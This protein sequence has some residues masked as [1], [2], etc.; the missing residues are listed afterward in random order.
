[1]KKR[2]LMLLTVALAGSGL[3]NAQADCAREAALAYDQAKAKNYDAALP[4]LQKIRETCPKYSMATYQYLERAL[5]AKIDKAPEGQ[6]EQYVEDLIEVWEQRLELYPEKTQKGK[7]YADIAQLKYDNKLGD[8]EELYEAYDKAWNEDKESFTSP[9]G[10]YA[11]FDLVVNMQD[12]GERSLQDVFDQYD[13]VF[14]KIEQEEND[15]AEALAPLL[16]KQEEGEELTAK[17]KKQIKY[18]EINLN[19]YSKVKAALNAKLGARADCDNL[20]PLYKK[21]FE[22]KKTDVSWLRNANAR[23]SAKDCTEDPLFVQVSEALHKLEPSAKS[24]FSLGQL[25][26]ANG[27]GAKALQYYNEAAELETNKSDKARIYYRI[28]GNYKDKGSYG[29]ARSFYRKA[30]DAKPSLGSAYL[31]IA[32]MYAKSANSCGTDTFTKRA[33]Y[34]LAADYASRAARV[35]PSIASNANQAASSYRGL[36]PQKSDIFQSSYNA[37]QTIS[38]GCWIGESVRVPNL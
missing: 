28:A 12:A 31:Q 6:K 25:A 13:K 34:W 38:I 16:K 5:E 23:L 30:L 15:A 17:E 22:A 27:D 29:Q 11:Y 2:I 24:A 14:G 32:S 3:A 4:A 21:D 33:V 20:I 8:E 7:I 9:K 10:L 18:S 36:A 37:G 19:N 1:M 35:D 26:E